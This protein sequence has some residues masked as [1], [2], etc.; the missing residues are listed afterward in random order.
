MSRIS[1]PSDVVLAI[2]LYV[3]SVRRMARA[4]VPMCLGALERS[5]GHRNSSMYFQAE[6]PIC[7]EDSTLQWVSD[8]NWTCSSLSTVEK[9]IHTN[10]PILSYITL[11]QRVHLV[12][13]FGRIKSQGGDSRNVFVQWNSRS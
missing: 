1:L 6:V 5:T 8:Q 9:N 4:V 2:D 13:L 3:Y 10:I 11:C 7:T 12:L